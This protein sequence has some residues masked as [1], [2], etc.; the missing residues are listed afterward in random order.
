MRLS[1][2]WSRMEVLSCEIF[3]SL[4][5]PELDNP[6]NDELGSSISPIENAT[7]ERIGHSKPLYLCRL[8]VRTALRRGFNPNPLSSSPVKA[9]FFNRPYRYF[10]SNRSSLPGWLGMKVSVANT[11]VFPFNIKVMSSREYFLK[12][13]LAHQAA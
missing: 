9:L 7:Q 5:C 1:W 6:P 8:T 2:H 10:R 12:A 4:C 13:P 3:G 11:T